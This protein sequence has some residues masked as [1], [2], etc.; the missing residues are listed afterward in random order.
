MRLL[1]RAT[2]VR[3]APIGGEPAHRGTL[4]DQQITVVVHGQA[5]GMEEVGGRR[6]RAV[7]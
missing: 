4:V 3:S 1:D 2:T 7:G 5:V 6:R